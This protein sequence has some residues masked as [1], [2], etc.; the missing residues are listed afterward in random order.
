VLEH[1][2]ASYDITRRI[3]KVAHTLTTLAGWVGVDSRGPSSLYLVADSRITWLTNGVTGSQTGEPTWDN[4]RKTFAS[5]TSAEVFGYAGDV[6]FPTQTV[7][8]IAD[9]I[10]RG[11]APIDG[12]TPE[13]RL[14]WIA[15][16]LEASCK[17]YPVAASRDFSLLYCGR[18]GEGMTC[19]FY[20]FALGFKQGVLATQT[21]IPIPASSGPLTYFDGKERFAFGSGRDGFKQCWEKW[22]A[23]EVGG[24]SRSVFSAFTDHIK[25]GT[26]PYTG[27]PPQLVGIYRA[28][29]AKSFGIVWE[30]RRFLGGMEVFAVEDEK[31]L[32]WHNDLFEICDPGS[33]GR[34]QGAQPQPRP[35][36]L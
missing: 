6:L 17:T 28:K 35:R 16:S 21:P 20:A 22:R 19:C 3:R 11:A 23:S 34:A 27:G 14:A 4:G 8:Q 2:T 1:Q 10:D 26:D 9:L 30:Q 7:G 12:A 36:S 25:S 5:H 13:R 31:R 24:T 18:Q 32:K 33:M 15:K 29:P